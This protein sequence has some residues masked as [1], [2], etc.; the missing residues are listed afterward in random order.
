[1]VGVGPTVPPNSISPFFFTASAAWGF[2]T[3]L[4]KSPTNWAGL[5]TRT[6]FVGGNI[7]PLKLTCGRRD[8]FTTGPGPDVGGSKPGKEGWDQMPAKSGID[9]MPCVS[10]PPGA[11]GCTCP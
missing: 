1:M 8:L 2:K 6:L 11:A 10:P 5:L 9:A 4:V 7:W 3:G